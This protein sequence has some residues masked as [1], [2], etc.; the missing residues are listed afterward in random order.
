MYAHTCVISVDITMSGED[1]CDAYD[2]DMHSGRHPQ[3]S[4]SRTNQILGEH[5]TTSLT[6]TTGRW[7]TCG[8]SSSCTFSNVCCAV[9]IAVGCSKTRTIIV[10][11]AVMIRQRLTH[12]E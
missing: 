8:L 12:T 3:S 4:V 2:F 6:Q 11:V 1:S 7:A 5:S 9:I 10:R